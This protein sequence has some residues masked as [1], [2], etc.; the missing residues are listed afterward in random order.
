MVFGARGLCKKWRILKSMGAWFWVSGIG[1][2]LSGLRISARVRVV[3]KT[4][5]KGFRKAR[6]YWPSFYSA[7]GERSRRTRVV[8]LAWVLGYQRAAGRF[9]VWMHHCAD[10]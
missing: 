2:G 10:P 6:A 4:L 8:G 9:S 5:P 7:Q 3:R 1:C